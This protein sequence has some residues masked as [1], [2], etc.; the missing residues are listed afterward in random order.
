MA[1]IYSYDDFVKAAQGAGLWGQF[2]DADLRLA[3]QNPDFG[4]Y[5]LNA[6][7]QYANAQTPEA[8][9]LINADLEAQRRSL[10]G[11]YGGT[12]GSGYNPVLAMPNSTWNSAIDAKT[13]QYN[14]YPSFSYAPDVTGKYR[15]IYD[16]QL[17]SV[18]DYAPFSYDPNTDPLYG[19]YK[20]AY[21]REGQRATA[22][23][24]GQLAG[25]TGGIPS[26][27]AATAAAQTGNYYAAQLADKIPD[28]YQ[29]AY[30]QYADQYNR[31]VQNAGLAGN[32]YGIALDQYNTDRNFAYNNYADDF[33]RIG[34]QLGLMTEQDNT[35]YQRNQT[36]MNDARSR[37]E[38]FLAAGGDINNLPADLRAASGLSDAEL[39]TLA[40]YAAT[41]RYS[42]R[43]GKAATED[44]AGLSESDFGALRNTIRTIAQTDPAQAAAIFQSNFGKLSREQQRLIGSD[45]AG[46]LG[47]DLNTVWSGLT[48]ELIGFYG[49]QLTPQQT[50][51]D[52]GSVNDYD[53]ALKLLNK[54]GS[55]KTPLTVEQ[56][57]YTKQNGQTQFNTYSDYLKAFV[58]YNLNG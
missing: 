9:A 44:A 8:R 53:S 54:Y 19:Y 13:A 2:S 34:A 33:N 29:L 10:G 38:A 22:D 6:K 23:T 14:N 49:E 25:A 39:N 12:D 35:A 45:V 50:G 4:Y 11:Y 57:N 5:A 42:G 32:R 51:V 37:I 56:W 43:G 20:Q 21:N 24:I 16:Q 31:N 17:Q 26:S 41:G 58:D 30:Q 48:P 18:Y 52:V 28:L 3:Q 7:Q 40:L 55:T 15:D 46:N 1:N 47:M 27:Y 36:A